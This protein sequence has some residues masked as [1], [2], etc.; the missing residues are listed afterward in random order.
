MN[1][2]SEKPVII[3]KIFPEL[4]KILDMEDDMLRYSLILKM[5]EFIKKNSAILIP[6][7]KPNLDS[8]NP[9]KKESIL[10]LLSFALD[11][12]H[13]IIP[14]LSLIAQQL[15]APEDYLVKKAKD[16]LI[17]LGNHEPEIVKI[18]LLKLIQ[19]KSSEEF[20]ENARDVLKNFIDASTA[21]LEQIK[22]ME[23]E[24]KK[25]I[26]EKEKA[27]LKEISQIDKEE[28]EPDEIHVKL[29]EKQAELSTREKELEFMKLK[30]KEEELK[31]KEGV[32]LKEKEAL[33]EEARLQK[34][35]ETLEKVKK[36][37]EE[38]QLREEK[39]KLLAMEEKRISEKLKALEEDDDSDDYE[40]IK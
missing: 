8:D 35:K 33:D 36:E 22:Q 4:I 19:S 2:I 12:S 30:L 27:V 23:L 38:K 28:V 7:I 1:I 13:D 14:F 5:E 29:M 11:N 24:A 31:L 20:G 37:L 18:E 32:I 21:S 16:V 34:E 9:R 17:G 25:E 40:E 39:E 10:Y 15:S 26:L 3:E 6:Y